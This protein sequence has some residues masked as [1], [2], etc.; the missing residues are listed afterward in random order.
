MAGFTQKED[1]ELQVQRKVYKACGVLGLVFKEKWTASQ[2]KEHFAICVKSMHPDHPNF[3]PGS[4][5][6]IQEL[7][8]AKDYLVK[9][10]EK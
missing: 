1:T 4:V 3:K 7:R 8:Q 5:R 9:F 10:L 2:V 6:E